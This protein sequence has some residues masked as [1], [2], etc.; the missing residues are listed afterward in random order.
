[1]SAGAG[2]ASLGSL[3]LADKFPLRPS[4]GTKGSSVVLWANY[5]AL[6]ASPQ[7]V[8][9]RYDVSVT[10][11]AAGKKAVQIIRLLLKTPELLPLEADLVTDFRS[12]LISRKK[13]DDKTITVT[14]RDEDEDEPKANA[15]QYAVKLKFTNVLSVSQLTEYLNSTNISA[16]Y[17]EKLEMIQAFN[18]FLNHYA[19]SSMNLATIGSSKTFSLADPEKYD[20]TNCLS[21]M[22]GFFSSVRAATARVLVNV[23][24]THS[25]FYTEGRL[26]QIIARHQFF[27]Q[28]K[29]MK[30]QK[31]MKGIKIRSTHLKEKKNKSGKVIV[32]RKTIYGFASPNDGSRLEHPPNVRTF[33]A[34]PK[35]VQFWLDENPPSSSEAPSASSPTG[36]KKGGKGK[37]KGKGPE[38]AGKSTTASGRYISVYDFFATK[39]G[40]RIENPQLPVINVGTKDNPSY[41]PL[42]VCVILPDAPAHKQLDSTQTQNMVRFAV[43]KPNENAISI[44]TKGRE[45]A[46]LSPATNPRLATFG[47]TISSGLITVPGRVLICP[48]VLYKQNL[49][50]QIRGASW[51]MV[52]NNNSSSFKFNA[53][54]ARLEK[55]SCLCVNMRDQYPNAWFFN[56]NS[57]KAVVNEFH[58]V[59]LDTGMAVAAPL[60]PKIVELRGDGT[61]DPELEKQLAG[62]ASKLQLLLVILPTGP[63]P[64]YN[65]IKQLCDVKYGIH[66]ICSVGSKIA[67][68]Q[69]QYLRN[70]ALKV[71]LKL[72]GN[73][74]AVNATNLS[75]I[76]EKKTM[77]VG[78]DVT[79]PSPG[80]RASAPSVAAMVAT[81][82]DSLGQW[83]GILGIQ[84]KS[85]QEMVSNL[86]GMLTSRLDL[87]HKKQKTL[88]ENILVYRDGVSE[89]QY[90][91]VLEEELPL[92]RAACEKKYPPADQKKGLPRMTV[93]IVGKRHHTRFYPTSTADMDRDNSKPGTVVDRGVTEA[94]SWDFFLQAHSA[95]Q[96]TARPAHYFVVLDEIFRA[97]YG[98]V[99]K[100]PAMRNIADEVQELTQSLC[101]VF[102]RATKAVSYC[103]PA[104]YA[105]I[106]C[107]RARRYLHHYFEDSSGG[108]SVAESSATGEVEAG[109]KDIKIHDRLKNTMF[110][111]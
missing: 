109:E 61:E 104:Y 32:K 106:L 12:T 6:E 96:G 25:P 29:V 48:K 36:K 14:Y 78:I 108:G 65:R 111:I 30:L 3:T 74:Q 2:A 103:T 42:Q 53:A 51:N 45:V 16:R 84:E 20:L 102:G 87:W 72:G 56:D 24:I 38:P 52:S 95:L 90:Q 15:R 58:R 21:A 1:M 97:R 86:E 88:P 70:E 17:G 46:G 76:A 91:T 10:P 8:L 40:I 94:R 54:G 35:D 82:D 28:R 89:G 33:A 44:T 23:N 75:V 43:R 37:G 105:D 69:D 107:E 98:G 4:Y 60:P 19:K 93:I 22:R 81:I 66:T 5:F 59:L 26:D 63:I 41:L 68:C 49:P 34:G 110:Y 31:F 47:I 101:Y 55:W 64:V 27:Q 71:N 13:F 100:K 62:A 7:L 50:A 18:V 9:Q 85:R 99:G 57:L 73:N 83:P 39:H 92:L 80:S 79:H 11:E 77:V 67:K